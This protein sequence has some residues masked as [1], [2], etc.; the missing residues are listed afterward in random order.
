MLPEDRCGKIRGFCTT[1]RNIFV[2]QSAI[3]H[4]AQLLSTKYRQ[5]TDSFRD[6]ITTAGLS[7]WPWQWNQQ[8]IYSFTFGMTNG[9]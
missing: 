2:T 7:V 8:C 5:M 4:V 9:R 1:A 3:V 6:D